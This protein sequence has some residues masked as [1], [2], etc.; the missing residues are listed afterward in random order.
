MIDNKQNNLIE[1]TSSITLQ[2]NGV[3]RKYPLRFVGILDPT[4]S[5]SAMMFIFF[6]TPVK[7]YSN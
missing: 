4:P 2:K 3:S 7:N 5:S 1:L 6:D